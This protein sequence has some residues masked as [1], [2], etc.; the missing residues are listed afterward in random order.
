[1]LQ[2]DLSKWFDSSKGGGTWVDISR[3]NDDG[4]HPE[5]GENTDR[6]G[7]AK[8]VPK[9]KAKQMSD[10]EKKRLVRR[11]RDKDTDSQSPDNASSD[12]S[13]QRKNE[14]VMKNTKKALRLIEDEENV[15]KDQD[16]WDDVIAVTKGEKQS[17]SA[18]GETVEAPNDGDGFDVYPSAYANGWAT[19]MYKKL[20]GEWETKDESV[21]KTAI[22]LGVLNEDLDQWFDEEWVD[23]SETDEDGNH[24]ACGEMSDTE[25]REND[26]ENN[27]PKCVPKSK[28]DDM[29]DAEKEELVKSKQQSVNQ[30]DEDQD[31]ED[32]SSDD[33]TYTSSD[34]DEHYKTNKTNMKEKQ[35]RNL[36]REEAKTLLTES[37]S[38]E[39]YQ[40][41]VDQ[42]RAQYPFLGPFKVDQKAMGG[43]PRIVFYADNG[44]GGREMHYI[45]LAD[46]GMSREV[47]VILREAS[48][49]VVDN[50]GE[51]KPGAVPKIIR[52]LLLP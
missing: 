11:K 9:Q 8:C 33:P 13:D 26:P 6:Q 38:M 45:V 12:P 10:K 49:R 52:N 42:L 19:K 25:K 30:D 24:P 32:G 22:K 46:V 48:G 3:T 4:E 47:D 29:T 31:S 18:N 16:L 44:S 28:A 40:N 37:A 50:V 5:C 36:I 2:E 21:T 27:Y 15:P 41:T 7:K 17:V 43:N 14:L 1:M 34:P 51:V 35:L 23:I 39:L 20:G